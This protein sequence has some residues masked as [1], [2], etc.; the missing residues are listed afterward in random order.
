MAKIEFSFEMG[1]WA[2]L[3]GATY[4]AGNGTSVHRQTKV[5]Q[6]LFF[7]ETS[8]KAHKNGFQLEL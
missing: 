4:F 8:L 5:E 7:K 2:P 3:G 6:F 1:K